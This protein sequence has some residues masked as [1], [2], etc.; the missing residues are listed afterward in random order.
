[1]SGSQSPKPGSDPVEVIMAGRRRHR[2]G[3]GFGGRNAFEQPLLAILEANPQPPVFLAEIDGFD[4][5]RFDRKFFHLFYLR[6]LIWPKI[7]PNVQRRGE[8]A[9]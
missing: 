6:F 2:H 3:V 9:W 7:N 1:L 8:A 5:L 4:D